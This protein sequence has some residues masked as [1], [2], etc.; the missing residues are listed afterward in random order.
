MGHDI[1]A[2]KVKIHTEKEA[3]Y[4]RRS[5]FDTDNFIIYEALDCTELY[6]GFSGVG[7]TRIFTKE[8]LNDALNYIKG[9]ENFKDIL[10]KEVNFLESCIKQLDEKNEDEAIMITFF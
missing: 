8:E 1:T 3:A 4:L 5:A 10:K 6:G 7:G 9:H 2:F